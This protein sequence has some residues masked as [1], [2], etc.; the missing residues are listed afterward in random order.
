MSL[1]HETAENR[2]KIADIIESKRVADKIVS[3]LYYEKAA[4]EARFTVPEA[5]SR[6]YGKYWFYQLFESTAGI[7][8]AEACEGSW[9]LDV[10]A[11]I[12]ASQVTHG[13]YGCP[14]S[15]IF[16]QMATLV[17]TRSIQT[18]IGE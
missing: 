16:G 7:L 18:G 6:K 10:E 4:V 15:R 12:D 5:P 1:L 17:A 8:G 13:G 11:S 9:V 3:I 2:E 14:E